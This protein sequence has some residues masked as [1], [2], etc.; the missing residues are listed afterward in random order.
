MTKQQ[1]I[2]TIKKEIQSTEESIQYYR[3]RMD[4]TEDQ[5]TIEMYERSI[6]WSKGEWMGYQKILSAI[7]SK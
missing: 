1:I 7:E 4:E 3:E 6:M 2:D 5:S